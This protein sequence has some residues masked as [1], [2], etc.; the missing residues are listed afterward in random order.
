MGSQGCR[1]YEKKLVVAAR[2]MARV[3]TWGLRQE[4]FAVF[5]GNVG[6][7][8]DSWSCSFVIY[9]MLVGK[10]P[11]NMPQLVRDITPKEVGDTLCL[12]VD[13]TSDYWCGHRRPEL[14]RKAAVFPM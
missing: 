5:C 10:K 6:F 12:M 1:L 14:T 11:F 2:G 9:R 3:H 13:F 7:P 8:A 4:R